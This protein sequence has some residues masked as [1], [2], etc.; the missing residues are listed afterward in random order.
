M[1]SMTIRVV[2]MLSMILTVA[3]GHVL[4]AAVTDRTIVAEG[5]AKA[6]DQTWQVAADASI[7]VENIRGRVQIRGWDRNQVS[8]RGSLGAGSR[9]EISGSPQHLELQVKSNEHGW[10]DGSG[11]KA[12]S[13]LIVQVPRK[14]KLEVHVI[15]ADA[16]IADVAGDSLQVKGVSGT[17]SVS[18]GSR[19]AE[20]T[21]V[22]GDVGLNAIGDAMTRVHVQTV[23]GDI[24]ATHLRGRIKL[25]TVSG[26]IQAQAAQAS[27]LETGSVSGDASISTTLTD[28]ARVHMESMSGDVRLNL[29]STLSARIDASTFSGDI[30]SDYGKPQTPEHGPGSHLDTQVGNG[31]AQL[32][33]QTFSGNIQLL[34]TGG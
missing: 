29:P 24:K 25:E 23:S 17:L 33:L 18:G 34:K 7:D 30:R 14:V 9:L 12:D 26:N 31:D 22:S 6:L 15:S 1:K 2:L 32:S 10:F 13:T 19:D 3:I 20:V 8:L 27:D 5:S 11:P 21:S 28:H 4:A 16:D